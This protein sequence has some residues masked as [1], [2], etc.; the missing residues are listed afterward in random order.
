VNG[1]RTDPPLQLQLL[2]AQQLLLASVIMRVIACITTGSL[3]A[4]QQASCCL[5]RLLASPFK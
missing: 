5:L 1:R 4:L 3:Y 2:L